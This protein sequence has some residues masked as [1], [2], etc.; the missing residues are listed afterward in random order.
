[1]RHPAPRRAGARLSASDRKPNY[2]L[3]KVRSDQERD[4]HRDPAVV[5][6]RQYEQR[7]PFTDTGVQL[8]AG[9]AVRLDERRVCDEDVQNL[10]EEVEQT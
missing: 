5:M 8:A 7:D 10:D 4:S 1:M 3:A 6:L 9:D 2:L